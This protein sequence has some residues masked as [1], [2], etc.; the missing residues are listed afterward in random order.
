PGESPQ[1]NV[2]EEIVVG[3]ARENW[4]AQ[5]TFAVRVNRGDK[6]FPL[7]SD[8]LARRLGAAILERTDWSRVNLSRPDQSFYVDI[9]PEGVYLYDGRYR[10]LGGLPVFT[11]GPVLS[12]LSGG[13]DSPVAAF[14]MAKRGCRVNFLHLTATHVAPERLRENLVSRIAQRLS[15]YTLHSRLFL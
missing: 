5:A 3:M 14:L 2:I 7:R 8:E 10:G 11:A 15:A 4:R 12:L 9:Y 1:P 13:I 6:G